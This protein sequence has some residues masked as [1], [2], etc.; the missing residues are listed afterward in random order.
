MQSYKRTELKGA[1]KIPA[2]RQTET[3]SIAVAVYNGEAYL[4]RCIDSLLNQT[5]QN[6]EIILVDDGSTDES[7]RIC[8]A[9]A[10]KDP[11]VKVVHKKNGGLAS[12]RN[13]GID[14][15]T[16][17]YMAFF[18][19]D[20]WAEPEMYE[21]LL[22]ALKEFGADLA[23]TRYRWVYQDGTAEASTDSVILMEG[24]EAL[25][26]YI[27]ENDAIQIQNAAWNKLYP[28]ALIGD[29]RF[30][31][32]RWYEDVLYTTKLLT[33]VSKVIYLD[34]ALYNY[35]CDRPGSYMNQGVSPRILTDLIPIFRDRSAFL[36]EIG[37]EDLACLHNTFF[38][39]RLLQ[40]YRQA[41]QSSEAPEE[42]ERK[43]RQLREEILRE[44]PNFDKAYAAEGV[45]PNEKRKMQLF[46]FSPRLYL[47]AMDA[48]EKWIVPLKQKLRS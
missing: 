30:E 3:I 25:E 38:Y 48:D 13:A 44:R 26:Q 42:K 10:K 37:R 1:G 34:Q 11:R 18:D 16:G 4:H 6:L 14:A 24:Q 43:M 40:Y 21:N 7:P 27:H 28:R 5:Y 35:V 23:V 47:L 12:G 31:E 15:A 22:W 33:K 9:Y 8:D 45:S 41:A 36:K 39:K 46:L 2:D 19:E 17:T 29:L 32:N 20:D